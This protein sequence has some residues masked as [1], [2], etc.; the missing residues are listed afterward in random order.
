M[1]VHRASPDALRAPGRAAAGAAR[2]APSPPAGLLRLQQT[3]GNA[4]VAGLV[5]ARQLAT[6]HAPGGGPATLA[7]RP[8]LRLGDIDQQVGVA[9]QKLNV[10]GATPELKIDA[11][12]GSRTQAAVRRFQTTNGLPSSAVLDTA[13]WAQLDTRAP[14]GDLQPDGSVTAVPGLHPGDPTPQPRPGVATHPTLRLT[15]H[16][17]AVSELHEKL[18]ALGIG[19]GLPI[20]SGLAG[21]DAVTFEAATEAAVR[22]FQ[23]AHPHSPSTDRWGSTRGPPSTASCPVRGPADSRRRVSGTPRGASSSTPTPPSTGPSNRTARRPPGSP[24]V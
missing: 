8:T 20:G 6:A 14:G 16:G 9:Q 3:A 15:S 7:A 21:A 19:S 11:E 2:R 5:A 23:R 12:F 10:L 17:P 18:N 4:A 24:H 13:T 22:T 1:G